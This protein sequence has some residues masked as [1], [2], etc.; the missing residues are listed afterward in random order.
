MC[1]AIAGIRCTP[2]GWRASQ[3]WI[4]NDR[5]LRALIAEMRQVSAKATELITKHQSQAEPRFNRKLDDTSEPV[6]AANCAAA[7]SASSRAPR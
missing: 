3:E 1:D 5:E 2:T 4:R 6:E 7:A